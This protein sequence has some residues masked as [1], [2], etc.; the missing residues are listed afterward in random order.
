MYLRE[1]LGL[2]DNESRLYLNPFKAVGYSLR[3]ESLLL[4]VDRNEKDIFS[5]QLFH[6]Y[7][8]LHYFTAD[9]K[10]HKSCDNGLT[11]YLASV[12][13]LGNRRSSEGLRTFSPSH[14]ANLAVLLM[15]A[16]DIEMNPGPRFQCR[17]CK[18]YC[19]TSYKVVECEDCKKAF[20]YNLFRTWQ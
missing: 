6:F 1:P 20:S 18:K 7:Q 11:Q 3:T 9:M 14:G 10:S 4:R 5:C 16:G 15:V 8:L 2:R 12:R 13:K 19:K 17:L